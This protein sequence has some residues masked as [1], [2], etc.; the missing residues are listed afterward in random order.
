MTFQAKR[1]LSEEQ[2]GKIMDDCQLSR[3]VNYTIGMSVKVS[4]ESLVHILLRNT[5]I[6]DKI[7][8]DRL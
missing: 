3:F 2:R 5:V 7:E 8:L 1:F 6:A 4:I